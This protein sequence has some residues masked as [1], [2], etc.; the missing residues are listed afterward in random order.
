MDKIGALI[1]SCGFTEHQIDT[2][3]SGYCGTFAIAL[4]RVLLRR[5]I[6]NQ[7]VLFCL[8]REDGKIA[9]DKD[10]VPW[11]RHVAVKVGDRYYDIEGHQEPEWIIDN[12]CWAH[13][14]GADVLPVS[15]EDLIPILRK[16]NESHST[17]YL[18]DWMKNLDQV[19]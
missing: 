3:T 1:A 13:V 11:W 17:S 19:G 15:E 5:G 4:H 7:L 8:K 16:T 2:A 12:Y 10:G 14:G 18:K 9:W 6:P